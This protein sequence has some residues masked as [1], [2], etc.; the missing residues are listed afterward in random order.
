M[1]FTEGKVVELEDQSP[2]NNLR[3]DGKTEK[4]NETWDECEQEV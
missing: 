3:I 1:K 4:E 2:R